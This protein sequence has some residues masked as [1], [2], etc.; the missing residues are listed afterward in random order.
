[1]QGDALNGLGFGF[2]AYWKMLRRLSCTF[3]I[4]SA[5]FLPQMIICVLTGGMAGQEN[6][7]N[8]V[9]TLGNLGFSSSECISQYAT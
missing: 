8:D 3:L 1:L 6:Y 9:W 5:I 2:E 7:A 4:I